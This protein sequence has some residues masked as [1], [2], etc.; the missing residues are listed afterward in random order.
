MCHLNRM[1]SITTPNR[2]LQCACQEH[3]F[4]ALVLTD[5]DG[6]ALAYAL[7][8]GA[9]MMA[10]PDGVDTDMVAATSALA[11]R[12]VQRM[13]EMAG[14]DG[15]EECTFSNRVG[16][17][18]VCRLF[19]AMGQTMILVALLP[20]YTAYRRITTTLVHELKRLLETPVTSDVG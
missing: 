7:G 1:N 14:M 6:F 18:M 5:A 8:A 12:M 16:R 17:R 9:Q 20:S 3:G 10:T 19:E 11:W 4:D 2:L 13:Q 15:I